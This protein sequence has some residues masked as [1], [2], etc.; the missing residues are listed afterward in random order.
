[1][2]KLVIATKARG[3]VVASY[4]SQFKSALKFMAFDKLTPHRLAVIF[5][6][7]EEVDTIYELSDIGVP[8][9]VT[10]N[11]NVEAEF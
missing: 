10:D 4:S 5:N 1:M 11:Y 9:E 7:N 3:K 2:Y 8:I 6:E